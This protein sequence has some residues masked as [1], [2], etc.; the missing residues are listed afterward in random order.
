VDVPEALEESPT[1]LS[2]AP[3][4]QS[5]ELALVTEQ[6]AVI[7]PALEPVAGDPVP[8]DLSGESEPEPEPELPQLTLTII[9]T[10]QLDPA[11]VSDRPPTIADLPAPLNLVIENGNGVKGIARATSNLLA[12]EKLDITGVRD[13]E[14]FDY[15]QTVIYYRPELYPY[16]QELAASLNLS[17]ELLPSEQLADGADVQV[18]LGH[19][20]ASQVN[21]QGGDLA[22]ESSPNS[23]YLASTLRLEVA[24]GNGVNGMAARVRKYLREQGSNVIGIYDADNFDYDE[25]LLYYRSGSRIAAE[26][27]AARLPLAGIRLIETENLRFETD[28]RLVI[29]KDYL[30]YDNLVMN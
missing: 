9:D 5:A 15:A 8:A 7:V 16:A 26:G 29:G 4:G 28:A 18:V 30:P 2:P 22:F 23:D 24:N 1:T 12:Q 11:R 19:D 10:P 21:V 13:A 3:E 20:F 14:H 6:A 17:C 27:L 25:T